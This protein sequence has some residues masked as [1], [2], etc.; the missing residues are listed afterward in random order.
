MIFPFL[1]PEFDKL[2][3][4]LFGLRSISTSLKLFALKRKTENNV[5]IHMVIRPCPKYIYQYDVCV[6]SFNL[7]ENCCISCIQDMDI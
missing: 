3:G 4:V 5:I 2:S 1:E 6:I 7:C